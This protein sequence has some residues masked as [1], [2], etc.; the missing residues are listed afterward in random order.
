MMEKVLKKGEDKQMRICKTLIATILVIGLVFE[1][2]FVA[3]AEDTESE[4][5]SWIEEEEEMDVSEDDELVSEDILSEP[6]KTEEVPDAEAEAIEPK[7]TIES[8]SMVAG[9]D[10]ISDPSIPEDRESSWANGEGNYVYLGSYYYTEDGEMKPIKWKVLSADN[11]AGKGASSLLL[12]T[13]SAIDEY[14]YDTDSNVWSNSDVRAWLNSEDGFLYNAFSEDEVS[15][16][17]PTYKDEEETVTSMQAPSLNGEKVFLLTGQ[18]LD[19]AKYGFYHVGSMLYTNASTRINAT[20]YAISKGVYC[21]DNACHYLTRSPSEYVGINISENSNYLMSVI[22][23]YKV[24][25]GSSN[26]QLIE[27]IVY[28]P[29]NNQTNLGLTYVGGGKYGGWFGRTS[30]DNETLGVAPAVNLNKAKIAYTTNENYE[31]PDSFVPMSSSE[32]TGVYNLTLY[33]KD[34]FE[35][36]KPASSEISL[37]EEI[38]ISIKKVP[39]IGDK[40]C[41]SQISAILLDSD[42]NVLAYG[43]VSDMLSSGDIAFKIPDTISLGNYTMR[44]FAEELNSKKT[45]HAVDFASN[46]LEFVISIIDKKEVEDKKSEETEKAS[47]VVPYTATKYTGSTIALRPKKNSVLTK[48]QF[49]ALWGKKIDEYNKGY[50]LEG[51]GDVFAEKAYECG[52]DPRWSPALA[53]VITN[54]GEN[55]DYPYN[56]WNIDNKMFGSWEES[57]IYC[58]NWLEC[59]YKNMDTDNM[60]NS[61]TNINTSIDS[62]KLKAEINSMGTY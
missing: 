35:A 39:V 14:I 47:I 6:T 17:S 42:N 33:G 43:K 5:N 45:P 23:N 1:H 38:K 25:D 37:G 2:S 50:P 3:F 55:C 16:L 27:K 13:D 52:I 57:I 24:G 29:Y 31:K 19:T 4:S 11:D 60:V 9:S 22:R 54:S 48:K 34:G 7:E 62:E 28:R 46:Y 59:D 12:V 41:Y 32:N 15:A 10:S 53:R 36:D 49:V 21:E 51:Y 30:C 58:I 40:Y 20:P 8:V 18:E 61:Y 26:G 56:A 44:L